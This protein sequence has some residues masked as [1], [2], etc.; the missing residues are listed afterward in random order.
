MKKV[1]IICLLI[2]FMTACSNDTK[3]TV[4]SER[5][6]SQ[7][8]LEDWSEEEIRLS[9]DEFK[10]YLDYLE[11]FQT[12]E[13]AGVL[14]LELLDNETIEAKVL[15]EIGSE[16]DISEAQTDFLDQNLRQ[17]YKASTYYQNQT[18]PTIR[19]VDSEGE[20][21]VAFNKSFEQR[22]KEKKEEIVASREDLGTFAMREEVEIGGANITFTGGTT[23]A[24]RLEDEIYSPKYVVR[25]GLS[26]ENVSTLSKYASA[27]AFIVEDF[28]RQE[29]DIYGL[30]DLVHERK[31]EPG[32]T[33][34]GPLY[35]TA[36]GNGPYR[37]TYQTDNYSVTW[38]IEDVEVGIP[39]HT[40]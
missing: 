17:A 33:I 29:L 8:G 10:Q 4:E 7:I 21:I 11:M 24:R 30:D 39:Q 18:E 6:W 34:H 13:N 40:N 32:N 35:F 3:Q 15:Q 16:E 19:F 26:F 38:L 14:T 25:M 20:E 1:V 27:R 36:S 31:V 9:K 28:S 23:V 37:I 22:E 5:D 2:G 12:K